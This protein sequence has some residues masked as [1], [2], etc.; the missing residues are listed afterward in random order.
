MTIT[1]TREQ[2]TI[3][4]I[5]STSQDRIKAIK[6]VLDNKQYAK[7]DGCMIDLTTA[8]VIMTVYN[9]LSD[10][11]KEKFSSFKAPVMGNMAYKLIK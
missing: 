2:G 7:I 5:T 1:R 6:S 8:H 3:E 4:T 11:N 9:A 10:P